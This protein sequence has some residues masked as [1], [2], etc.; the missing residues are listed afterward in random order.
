MEEILHQLIGT[1]ARYLQGF[2]HPRWCR[3][4]AINSSKKNPP[5]FF[6]KNYTFLQMADVPLRFV[7]LPEGY[8]VGESISLFSS[9]PTA[10]FVI[11]ECGYNLSNATE[12]PCIV[13]VGGWKKQKWSGACFPGGGFKYFFLTLTWG[14]HLTNIFQS[15]WNHHLGFF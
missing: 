2:L 8:P 13:F 4:S 6:N 1:L 9:I 10:G 7:R 14:Y 12:R 11:P 15:G 5:D 3:I